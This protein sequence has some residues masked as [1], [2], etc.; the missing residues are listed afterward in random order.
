MEVYL[1]KSAADDHLRAL[2][3]E[4]T[5][6]VLP[7]FLGPWQPY[8]TPGQ[9]MEHVTAVSDKIQGWLDTKG[10]YLIRVGTRQ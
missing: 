6:A 4:P 5:G 1:F 3:C 8:G 9:P 10:Y 2:T 7:Q